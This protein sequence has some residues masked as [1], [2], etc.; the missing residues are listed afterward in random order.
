MTSITLKQAEEIIDGAIAEGH[1]HN[2]MLAV[3]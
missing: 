3:V 2:F 1:K